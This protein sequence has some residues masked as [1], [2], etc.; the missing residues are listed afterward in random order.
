MNQRTV[1][2]PSVAETTTGSRSARVG[3]VV[4]TFDRPHL[5]G[6][7]IQSIL[8]QDYTDFHLVVVDDGS[9]V[10]GV[11]DVIASFD[12]DITF[13]VQE[14]QGIGA[15]RNTG[16]A[17]TRNELFAFLDDDDLWVPTKL[18]SQVAILDSEPNLEA[19]YGYAEQFYDPSVD[20]AFRLQHPI[21][22]PVVAARVAGSQLIR[23][24]AFL[25][26]GPYLVNHGSGI[27]VDW[28]LRAV[29]AQLRYRLTT[30]V[31]FRRRVHGHNQSLR[32]ANANLDRVKMLK[33]GLDRR[34]NLASQSE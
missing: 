20:E 4:P 22:D 8:D 32:N 14:N 11:A 23:R 18:S 34:R 1:L 7:S 27:D 17:A 21:K 26:V 6:D 15:A 13:I 29:E 3:V 9:S 16:I 19:V 12:A 28:Q 10:P 31:V 25:R 30:D 5:L 2:S 33:R 24:E